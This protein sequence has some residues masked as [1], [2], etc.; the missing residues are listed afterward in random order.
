MYSIR[1]S[2]GLGAAEKT[3][4][5]P[6]QNPHE[7]LAHL[8]LG[9][10]HMRLQRREIRQVGG[11][12]EQAEDAGACRFR[13]ESAGQ[14]EPENLREVVKEA[15]RG[16]QHR[17]V[18]GLK[19][20]KARGL[21][22]HPRRRRVENLRRRGGVHELQILRDE[23]DVDEGAGGV[24]EVPRIGVALFLRRSPRASR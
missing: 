17:G 4:R 3:L 12:R 7:T 23:L 13:V 16:P 8:A 20:V 15:H 19:H 2:R 22:Q 24:F 6:A 14:A 9:F 21:L 18:L 10:L 5:R 1:S 11:T